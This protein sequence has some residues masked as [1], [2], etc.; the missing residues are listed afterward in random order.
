MTDCDA[1]IRAE[2]GRL[3]E[4]ADRL[5]ATLAGDDAHDI[6]A[7]VAEL[8]AAFIKRYGRAMSTAQTAYEFGVSES[9][10]AKW[11]EAG[12]FPELAPERI[13]GTKPWKYSPQKVARFIISR[14]SR[15]N[16]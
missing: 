10:L 1:I 8:T 15:K 14:N 2:I 11:H 5:E 3:R 6:E 13:F 9:A 16:C 12:K 4:M 7:E